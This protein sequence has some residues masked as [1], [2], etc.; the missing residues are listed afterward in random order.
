RVDTPVN[1]E[2]E[3]ARPA[4]ADLAEMID[5]AERIDGRTVRYVRDDMPSMYRVLRLVTVLCSAPL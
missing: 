5:G 1:C 4:L 2:I 3:L